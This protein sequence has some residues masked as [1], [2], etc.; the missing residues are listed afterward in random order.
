MEEREDYSTDK[1]FIGRVVRYWRTKT[2]MSLRDLA[3]VS[4]VQFWQIQHIES[5]KAGT[6]L[7]TLHK[8]LKAMG[9][10]VKEAFREF[11][12]MEG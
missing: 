6:T 12:Q 5:G 1:K 11:I 2:K 9:T 4:G 3:A 7:Y 8:M 10:D